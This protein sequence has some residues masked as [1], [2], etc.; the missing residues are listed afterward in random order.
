MTNKISYED[1]LTS[2]SEREIGD[3]VNN[4]WLRFQQGSNSP[5]M[6]PQEYID[7][8]ALLNAV[9]TPKAPDAVS[10]DN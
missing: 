4:N 6:F 9:D 3:S 5:D 10:S 8:V 1:M 2:L 7:F